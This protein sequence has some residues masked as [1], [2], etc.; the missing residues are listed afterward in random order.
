MFPASVVDEFSKLALGR[1]AAEL[2]AS[3]ALRKGLDPTKLPAIQQVSNIAK[4]DRGRAAAVAQNVR[5]FLRAA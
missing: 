1:S 2:L 4:S 5:G 3:K